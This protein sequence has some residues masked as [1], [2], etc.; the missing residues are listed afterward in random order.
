MGWAGALA[1]IAV[2]VA[3]ICWLGAGRLAVAG[4]NTNQKPA[5]EEDAAEFIARYGVPDRDDSNQFLSPRPLMITRVLTY[6]DANV[7][8][9]CLPRAESGSQPP[10]KAWKLKF[11][12]DI[13]DN[14]ILTS[15]QVADRL[16]KRI[17]RP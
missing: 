5:R 1:G 17:L 15:D 6:D 8:V 3:V 14:A 12:Q 16:S 4:G 9:V 10:F 2:L 7:R 13:R 11:F